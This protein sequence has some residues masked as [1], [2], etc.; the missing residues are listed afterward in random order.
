MLQSLALGGNESNLEP[1]AEMS[2]SAAVPPVLVSIL[3]NKNRI[4]L[5]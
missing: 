3:Y 5:S 1:Q 4:F 2:K